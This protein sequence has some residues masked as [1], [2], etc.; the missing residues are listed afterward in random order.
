MRTP[1]LSPERWPPVPKT[2]SDAS[3]RSLIASLLLVAAVPTL[4]WPVDHPAPV[5]ASLDGYTT[6]H[7]AAKRWNDGEQNPCKRT[8]NSRLRQIR[9]HPSHEP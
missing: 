6:A 2:D 9:D 8:R 4:L 3:I 1:F 5:T 7:T